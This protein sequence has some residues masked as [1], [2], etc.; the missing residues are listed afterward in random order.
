MFVL[1]PINVFYF[2]L[3]PIWLCMLMLIGLRI[4]VTANPPLA[5]AT[6]EIVWLRWLLSDVRVSVSSPTPLHCDN[7]SA[8]TLPT[9]PSS[10]N[11]EAYWNWLPLCSSTSSVRHHYLTLSSSTLQLA[12]FFMKTHN[13][14]CFHFLL[15][16]LSMLSPLASWVSEEVWMYLLCI[17]IV[18]RCIF[19][20]KAEIMRRFSR[21]MFP[22]FEHCI[23][24][25]FYNILI[26]NTELLLLSFVMF[27]TH[28][29]GRIMGW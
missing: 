8:I 24:V 6:S 22:L 9:T 2:L 27:Q 4:L 20:F 11:A 13:A 5:H 25:V 15:G 26:S 21:V 14:A 19:L 18:S 23:R 12:K 28:P 17:L 16:K 10:M 29:N 7:K 1:L 3:H